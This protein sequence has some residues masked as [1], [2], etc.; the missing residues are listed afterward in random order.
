MEQ[1]L[2]RAREE[3]FIADK[4]KREAEENEKAAHKEAEQAHELA[5]AL[6]LVKSDIEKLLNVRE[7]IMALCNQSLSIN[8]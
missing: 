4:K 6:Q 7:A 3:S 5:F 8:A 2:K 1:S